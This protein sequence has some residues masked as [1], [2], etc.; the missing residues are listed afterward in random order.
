MNA[1]MFKN[2]IIA[3]VAMFTVV[4][5]VGAAI[6]MKAPAKKLPPAMLYWYPVDPV[7]KLTTG[8]QEFHNTKSNVLGQQGCQDADN[9]PICLYG[10]TSSSVAIGTDASTA[11][12][13]DLILQ[14]Q[15]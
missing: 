3:I 4:L 9:Q 13:E 1:K 11:P 2:K 15:P 7:S 10:S 14:S 5:S 6:A 8:A 12:R